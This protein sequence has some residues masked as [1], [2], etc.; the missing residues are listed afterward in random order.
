MGTGLS[1][2]AAMASLGFHRETALE[3]ARRYPEF[4]DALK[5]GKAKRTRI[6]EEQLLAAEQGPKVTARIFALKNA[7]PDEWAD[8]VVQQHTGPD[9]GPVQHN[10]KVEFVD[11]SASGV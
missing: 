5:L 7:A 2:T 1:L 8:K 4:S 11:P 3:W 6:L 10:I 9:G